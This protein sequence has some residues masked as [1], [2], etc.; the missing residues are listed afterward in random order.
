MKG[1]D[2]SL[3]QK[4][5]LLRCTQG[6]GHVISEVGWELLRSQVQILAEAKTLD[7]FFPSLKP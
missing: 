2:K 4:G 1:V 3:K 6:C 7:D 5:I